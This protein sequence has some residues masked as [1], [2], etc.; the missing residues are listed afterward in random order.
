[1]AQKPSTDIDS[2][3]DIKLSDRPFGL[4]DK[5][6]YFFG[7]FGNDFSFMFMSNFL[8]IFYTDALGISPAVAGTLFL[9]ARIIDA[10]ADVT[11]GRMVDNTKLT[12]YG[13]Y[14]P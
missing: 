7:D 14:I 8:M 1:M 12:K 2:K 3:V 10:F 5:I 9:V 6:G 13:R 4:S 11:I